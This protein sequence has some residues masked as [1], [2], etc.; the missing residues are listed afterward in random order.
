MPL[1]LSLIVGSILL[2]IY[3]PANRL[4][5]DLQQINRICSA[6]VIA[7]PLFYLSLAVVGHGVAIFPRYYAMFI[8]CA[9]VP[10]LMRCYQLLP[11]R[12]NMLLL[13][14]LPFLYLGQVGI[15]MPQSE[16]PLPAAA[17]R[18]NSGPEIVKFMRLD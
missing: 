3:I 16:Y 4:P 2:T 14:I 15:L 6:A 17:E 18:Y 8:P 7:F 11:R 1:T 5:P 9:A 13:G 12:R 10:A